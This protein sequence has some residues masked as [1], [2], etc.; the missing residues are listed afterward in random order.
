MKNWINYRHS[1]N[2]MN[3][4]RGYGRPQKYDLRT[5]R[6]FEELTEEN[7]KLRFAPAQ[8]TIEKMMNK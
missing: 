5:W 3:I 8:I 7:A 4:K 6:F 2:I 1:A